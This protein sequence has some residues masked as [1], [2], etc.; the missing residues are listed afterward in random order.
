M[1]DSPSLTNARHHDRRHHDRSDYA[2]PDYA[3]PGY[4]RPGYARSG[5]DRPDYDRSDYDRSD[6][7]RFDY[8]RFDHA[9]PGNSATRPDQNRPRPLLPCLFLP[10]TVLL[11]PILR[12]AMQRPALLCLMLLALIMLGGCASR[13]PSPYALDYQA[14][15]A[16]TE[17]Q[18][19]AAE[20]QAIE[21][22]LAVYRDLT[23]AALAERIDAAYQQRL[24][25]NDTLHTFTDRQALS[26]YLQQTAERVEH[27]EVHIDR[28]INDGSDTFV[29]WQMTTR[30]R[31]L[32][33]TMHANTIGITHLR[34]D[35]SGKVILHQDYWDST[36]GLFSQIPFIGP[37]LNWTRRRL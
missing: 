34:F 31:A 3:R 4:A 23:G 26:A 17:T 5:Y 9:R 19:R 35:D 20:P 27:I 16:A 22:F 8:D 2:Q 30:A 28:V 1:N 24:Y 36:E 32:G 21:R 37:L 18:A 11:H 15:M 25:F 14:A 29:H 7:D 6:Y 10:G 33:K 12:P 13:T